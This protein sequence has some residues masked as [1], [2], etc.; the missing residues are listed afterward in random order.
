ML[1]MKLKS[2]SF[3]FVKIF[4]HTQRVHVIYLSSITRKR[5]HAFQKCNARG[6]EHYIFEKPIGILRF[7][8]LIAT[9]LKTKLAQVFVLISRCNMIQRRKDL[10]FNTCTPTF[11]LSLHMGGL[12]V[13]GLTLKNCIDGARFKV[14]EQVPYQFLKV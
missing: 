5:Q 7:V 10:Q 6:S 1:H 11:S 14:Q 12:K 9:T 2:Q 8:R 3:L 13:R 4:R